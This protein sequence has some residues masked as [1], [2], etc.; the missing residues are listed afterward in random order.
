MPPNYSRRSTLENLRKFRLEH[1]CINIVNKI[2][3]IS[4]TAAVQNLKI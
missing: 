3:C 2:K 4:L 1:S